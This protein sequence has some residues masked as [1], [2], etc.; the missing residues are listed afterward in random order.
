MSFRAFDS[1]YGSGVRGGGLEFG[2]KLL[3]SPFF[4]EYEEGARNGFSN[5]LEGKV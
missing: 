2:F 5:T 3:S 4:I 1:D